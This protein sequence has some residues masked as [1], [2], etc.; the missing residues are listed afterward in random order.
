M[1]DA[2]TE[3]REIDP[4]SEALRIANK[5]MPG[6]GKAIY[7]AKD[8][9]GLVKTALAA[10]EEELTEAVREIERLK[11]LVGDP[12]GTAAHAEA[13][14]SRAERAEK[15]RDR[16]FDEASQHL[17]KITVLEAQLAEA[18]K[19]LDEIIGCFDAACAEGLQERLNDETE[20][21]IGTLHDLITR[22]IL[23]AYYAARCARKAQ[24]GREEHG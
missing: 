17:H 4:V 16:L 8:I 18:N 3:A 14:L 7:L 12:E 10:K 1:T 15:E 21:D 13:F 19:A 22:R 24:G 20:R 2:Q 5:H 9:S 6:N 23:Y 11:N